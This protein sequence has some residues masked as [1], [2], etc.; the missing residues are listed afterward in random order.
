M[1]TIIYIILLSMAVF[2][3]FF[4]LSSTPQPLEKPSTADK[5]VDA[6]KSL[7]GAGTKI[8]DNKANVHSKIIALAVYVV[9]IASLI[10]LYIIKG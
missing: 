2:S 7:F 1:I 4:A 6:L 8:A 9:S 3:G 10:T 5:E